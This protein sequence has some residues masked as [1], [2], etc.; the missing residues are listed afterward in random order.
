[1]SYIF[2]YDLGRRGNL[3]ADLSLVVIEGF[4][5]LGRR[6]ERQAEGSSI[7]FGFNRIDHLE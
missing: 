1:M 6:L 3:F 2:S 7:D 4:R 5:G